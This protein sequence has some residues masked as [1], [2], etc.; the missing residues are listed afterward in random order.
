MFIPGA[1][2]NSGSAEAASE[3]EYRV[4]F[5]GMWN[6]QSTPGGIVPGAHFTTFVGAVHNSNVTYWRSG[7]L[8]TPG[9]ENV[10]ELGATDRFQFEIYVSGDNKLSIIHERPGTGPE[11]SD[12]FDIK[13]TSDYPLVTLLSMIGP[14]PDWFV[15]ISG[16]SLLDGNGEWQTQR[17]INLY[18]HDAGTEEGTEFTLNNS[19]TNP[20]EAI[21]SIR[22]TGKFSNSPMATLTFTLKPTTTEPEAPK[23]LIGFPPYEPTFFVDMI[24]DVPPS[25]KLQVWNSRTGPMSFNVSDNSDWL[26][27]D[28]LSGSSSGPTDVEEID[29]RVDSSN[30]DLGYHRGTIEISGPGIENSPQ[31]VR[32][33]LAIGASGFSTSTSYAG[34]STSGSGGEDFAKRLVIPQDSLPSGTTIVVAKLKAMPEGAPLSDVA[35]KVVW[36]VNVKA[37]PSGSDVP[38][39]DYAPSGVELWLSMPSDDQPA[40]TEDRAKL[41]SVADGS[42]ELVEHR[43]GTYEDRTYAVI[44][45]MSVTTLAL[46]VEMNYDANRDGRIDRDEIIRAI[47]DYFDGLIDRDRVLRLIQRYF[48]DPES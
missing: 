21:S 29:V 13:V 25:Q 11:G 27:V 5:K 43:C 23:A 7:G 46:A 34:A 10:A 39:M 44:T 30:L 16:V 9:I 48:S 24:G 15:G 14:S 36:S 4:T 3:V 38:Y 8:A 41:Y 35:S 1:G 45:P 2:S 47:S 19:P 42:W 17:V 6:L 18:P 40:C 32:V 22:N 20:Q 31:R 12:T 28:P 26:T 33:E 37:Y